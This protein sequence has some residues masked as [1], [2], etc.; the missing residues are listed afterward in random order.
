MLANRGVKMTKTVTIL[1][2]T[3]E[4]DI[5]EIPVNP[6]TGDL[7]GNVVGFLWNEKP[8]GDFLLRR[9]EELLSQKYKQVR[10]TWEQVEGLHTSAEV[11]SEIQKIAAAA[12]TVLIATGD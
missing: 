2:P 7:N 9:I 6:R 11:A 3:A 5:K 8:N 12:D 10:T 1:V 4:N